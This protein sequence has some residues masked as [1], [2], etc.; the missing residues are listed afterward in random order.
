MYLKMQRAYRV[1]AEGLP[2]VTT[3][4]T[5]EQPKFP[6]P[7]DALPLPLLCSFVLKCVLFGKNTLPNGSQQIAV[8]SSPL[9]LDTACLSRHPQPSDPLGMRANVASPNTYATASTVL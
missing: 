8:P 9:L 5:P 7:S 1:R 4:S 2:L 6:E 3:F